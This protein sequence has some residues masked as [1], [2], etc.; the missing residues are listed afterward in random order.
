M[1]RTPIPESRTTDVRDLTAAER[2]S[3][4]TVGS[5]GIPAGLSVRFVPPKHV[6]TGDVFHV[7]ARLEHAGSAPLLVS[8]R[9]SAPTGLPLDRIRRRHSR[10]DRSGTSHC[11]HPSPL[12]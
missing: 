12:H 10:V 11:E 5:T 7:S 8:Q 2:P 4:S 1:L 3:G 9:H 6:H